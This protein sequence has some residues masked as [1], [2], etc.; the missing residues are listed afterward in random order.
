MLRHSIHLLFTQAWESN[1]GWPAGKG[2]LRFIAIRID[3]RQPD[4]ND[5]QS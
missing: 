5:R 1:M 3:R 2:H 4:G